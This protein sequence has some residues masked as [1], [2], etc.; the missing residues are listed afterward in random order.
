MLK[1][2]TTSIFRTSTIIGA[3]ATAF[4]V[5]CASDELDPDVPEV[6]A[7][8]IESRTFHT[9]GLE[10]HLSD[11]RGLKGKRF[12]AE[13]EKRPGVKTRASGLQFEVL[14]KGDGERP[15]LADTV[16]TQ[17][18]A[19][20]I[21]GEEVDNSQDYGGPQEFRVDKV[22]AGWREALQE[23]RVGAKWKLY[24]PPELAYGDQGM[25]QIPG[26]E[27]LIYELDLISIKRGGPT[28][29]ALEDIDPEPDRPVSNP[30]A[31]GTVPPDPPA[32][33]T[34]DFSLDNLDLLD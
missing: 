1:R 8:S 12:L 27:T 26:G 14:E 5:G 21:D 25:A 13:N 32:A 20:T 3:G 24:V 10:E 19:T 15:S 16:V 18:R 4:F 9:T 33:R 31:G 29:L 17:Y 28:E 7:A 34:G 2:P 23:M 22:I 30:A 6:E 11:A